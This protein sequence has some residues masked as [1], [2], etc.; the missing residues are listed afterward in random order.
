MATSING[1]GRQPAK[2][3]EEDSP[4][5]DGAVPREG[6]IGFLPT[7]MVGGVSLWSACFLGILMDP[8]ESERLSRGRLVAATGTPGPSRV[9]SSEDWGRGLLAPDGEEKVGSPIEESEEF[10]VFSGVSK[11]VELLP[12][13]NL[14]IA[15]RPWDC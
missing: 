11:S 9:L 3:F 6:L 2:G 13:F 15:P 7:T 10:I 14:G 5:L 4:T 8:H 1:V 12:D